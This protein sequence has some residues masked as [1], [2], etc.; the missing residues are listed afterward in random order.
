MTIQANFTISQYADGVIT[1]DMTPTVDIT[2]WDIRFYVMKRFGG[3]PLFTRSV[4]SGY[5]NVSGINITDYEVG[6]MDITINA[7]DMSGKCWGNYAYKC[8]RRNSGQVTP[9]AQ[10]FI[11]FTL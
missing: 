2:G 4:A 3:T 8:D 5:N 6:R 9:L 10:G 7:E 11:A 1:L